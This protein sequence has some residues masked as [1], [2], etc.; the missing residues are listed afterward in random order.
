MSNKKGRDNLTPWPK[1]ISGNPK[2]R[3]KLPD[4]RGALAAILADEQ[5]GMTA[6]DAILRSLRA[7][8][9]RGDIRAAEVLLDRA[10]GKA[11][12]PTDITSAGEAITVTPPI[13]WTDDAATPK[14]PATATRK[15]PRGSK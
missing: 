13:Q 7:K 5:Q 11:V 10:F 1:G 12:Q 9:I 15:G 4:I 14:P 6:L 2:G 8:A 3:P